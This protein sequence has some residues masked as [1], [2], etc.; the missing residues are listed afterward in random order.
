MI[1][2]E[3]GVININEDSFFMLLSL[4]LHLVCLYISV[5][6]FIFFDSNQN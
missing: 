3:I 2:V 4:V 6:V 5:D 1:L